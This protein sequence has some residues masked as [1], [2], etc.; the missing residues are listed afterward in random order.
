VQYP[1]KPGH[2]FY[3]PFFII[4]KT[5]SMKLSFRESLLWLPALLMSFTSLAQTSLHY[6]DFNTGVSG[7]PWATPIVATQTMGGGSLSHPYGAGTDAFAGSTQDAPGFTTA[8][9]GATFSVV[10][11]ANNGGAFILSVP[12]TGYQD[13]KYTY[14]TRGTAT[15]FT[16]HTIDYSADG[17]SFT[18]FATITGRTNTTFTL[19]TVDFTAITAANDNPNF[20]IRVTV[21]GATNATGNNRFDNMRIVGNTIAVAN[22]IAVAA[23]A[24][25]AEGGSNGT[26]GLALSPVTP[27]AVTV[28]YAFTGSATFTSDYTV[29]FTGATS[30]SSTA[31]GTLT[32]PTGTTAVT[33][34]ISPV[35]DALIETTET[36]TLTLT[37]PTGGYVL[38]ISSASI[39]LSDNDLAAIDFT[40]AYS[41]DFNTLSNTV[42]SSTLPQGWLF[43]ETGTGS[44]TTYGVDNGGSNAGNTYSYGASATTER[45]FGGLQSGA[46]VPTVGAMINNNTGATLGSFQ[47]T[48][49]GEQWRL[50]AVGRS[51]KLDFQYSLNATTLSNGTWVDVDGLDFIAP[52]SG[53]TV[54]AIDG[55]ATG[56]KTTINYTINGLSIPA[57]AN[58]MIRW[59][60]TDAS[61]S[62]DGL[63]IDDVSFSLGCV[64]PAAQPTLLNLTPALQAIGGTFT[65]AAGADSYLVLI[66]TSPTLTEQPVSGN[67]YNTDD[68][69]GNATVVSV[70]GLS[71]NA[72]GLTPSTTYYFFVYAMVAAS[73]CINTTA[74]LTGSI[75]TT[76][77]P[78]CTPPVTQASNLAAANI[79]GTSIDISYTRGSGDNVLVVARATDAINAGPINSLNYTVGTEIGS[80]N[81]VVFNGTAAGFTHSGLLQNTTYNYALYEYNSADFCYTAVP[82]TG[83]FMTACV[84]PVNVSAFGIGIGNALLN[85]NWTNPS[86]SCFDEIVI[87]ASTAPIAGTGDTYVALAN[88]VYGSGEQVVY[89]G[90][91]GTVTV[92]GLTNGTTY[93]FKAFTRKGI[94]YSAGIQASGSPFDPASGY[95][96]LY[97]NLHAH[98][99]YSDG[100]K[101]DLSKTPADDY[102]FARDALCMDFMGMSEHNHAGAGM[103]LPDYTLGYNQA[104]AINGVTGPHGNTLVTLFGMEWGVIKNG[105]HVLIYGFDNQL[106]GWEPGNYDIFVNKSTY[107]DLWPVINARPGAFA[108]LAG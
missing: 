79:T 85:V 96:Y 66:S 35:D 15:G 81:F 100:N 19:Q 17:V 105:G 62:D 72:A 43:S 1:F 73:N 6:W 31:S 54:G 90:T 2:P 69:I 56:N 71:F 20:K 88:P 74:A 84:T 40:G 5:T 18:N 14:S 101:A 29:S 21:T 32:I 27:G 23:G 11:N 41:H 98:S 30:N 67:P 103:N 91:G 22:S 10:G 24:N 48:Y 42:L 95:L 106:I 107:V 13:I 86:G 94:A 37:N 61:G 55:N 45:A 44:N 89:R 97:G 52:V 39:N 4:T 78:A 99:S 76:T 92:S 58:F 87:V 8:S 57:G 50:G 60:D 34:N 64:P 25:T 28:D 82:L 104:N 51:D 65:A 36:I 33:V 26:F 16:T 83:S 7:T 80:G 68:V 70:D 108:T 77:P 46:V 47:I 9:A 63:A 3:T 38:G 75:A 102:A 59:R 93:Y 12:T 49:T 53:G